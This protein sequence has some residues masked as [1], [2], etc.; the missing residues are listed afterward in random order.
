MK[1][2]RQ[3][4]DDRRTGFISTELPFMASGG[5]TVALERRLNQ[6]RR[7]GSSE[8]EWFDKKQRD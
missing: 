8:F 5:L 3:H 7:E 4:V 1:E 6:D 2:N